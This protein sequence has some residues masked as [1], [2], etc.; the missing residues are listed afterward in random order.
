MWLDEYETKSYP[1]LRYL[2]Y[3][4]STVAAASGHFYLA[5]EIH[6]QPDFDHVVHGVLS[7]C[8]SPAAIPAEV[9]SSVVSRAGASWEVVGTENTLENKLVAGQVCLVLW[10]S[11]Q[12]VYGTVCRSVFIFLNYV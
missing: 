5:H 4:R 3:P 9:M 2:S 11:Y 12:M 6:A 7:G 10:L 8:A 1:N